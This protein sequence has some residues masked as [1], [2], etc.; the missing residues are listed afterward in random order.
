VSTDIEPTDMRIELAED[1]TAEEF[2][3]DLRE[4]AEQGGADNP[5]PMAAGTFCMYA[6]PD[7][8]MMMVTSVAEGHPMAG[9][10][11]T[12]VPPGMIRAIT[13][14]SGGGSIGSA[15]RAAAIGGRRNRKAIER[16]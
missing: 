5:E 4:I 15:I 16:G 10:R 13:V 6:T 12:K 3:A 7:G 2:I 9:V 14:L 8:G 11:R 1:Y